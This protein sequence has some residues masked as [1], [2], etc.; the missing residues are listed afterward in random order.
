MSFLPTW[1]NLPPHHT[2]SPIKNPSLLLPSLS[3]LSLSPHIYIVSSL[4]SLPNS[5]KTNPP[6]PP[7]ISL[8]LLCSYLLY[9]QKKKKLLQTKEP[10]KVNISNTCILIHFLYWVFLYLYPNPHLFKLFLSKHGTLTL[11]WKSTHQQRCLDQR[12]RPAPH[13]LY[14]SPRWRLLAF[15]S[16]SRR[17]KKVTQDITWS[18][19]YF[20][21][22]FKYASNWYPSS[23]FYSNLS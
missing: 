12:G 7:F 23:C 10:K 22:I 15:S 16:Q 5:F 14:P 11:L 21:F 17:Y 8:S 20:L 13:R 9:F 1:S 18:Q 2:L 19:S 3:F 6:P 4:L